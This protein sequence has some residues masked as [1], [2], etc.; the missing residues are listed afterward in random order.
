M[1]ERKW[2]TTR[3]SMET[4]TGPPQ[5]KTLERGRSRGRRGDGGRGGRQGG[6]SRRANLLRTEILERKPRKQ[7]EELPKK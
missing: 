1:E 5:W 3:V 4:P 6:R 2:D 7:G